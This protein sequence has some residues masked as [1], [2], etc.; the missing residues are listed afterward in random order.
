MQLDD[1]RA[2]C[3][4]LTQSLANDPRV[5]GLIALGSMA[6]QDYLPDQRSD[7][8]FFVVT[9]AGQQ[10]ALRTDLSWLPDH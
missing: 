8:D 10:E 7:H 6:E 5:L 2:Y 4:A 9:V 3:T 1:Y